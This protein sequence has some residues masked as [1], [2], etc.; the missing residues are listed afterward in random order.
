M[1]IFK[2]KKGDR[3]KIVRDAFEDVIEYEDII[4]EVGGE[5]GIVNAVYDKRKLNRKHYLVIFNPEYGEMVMY[6]DE[7]ELEQ[8][9]KPIPKELFEI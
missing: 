7:L 4:D 1:G 6:E 5:V 3:V 9:I 8:L 2:F